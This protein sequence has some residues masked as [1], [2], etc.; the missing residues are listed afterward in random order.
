MAKDQDHMKDTKGDESRIVEGW[1][2]ISQEYRAGE[3]NEQE[4]AQFEK[5]RFADEQTQRR[6]F[7]LGGQINRNF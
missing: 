7:T 4:K 5:A 6:S 2:R 3:L 1:E